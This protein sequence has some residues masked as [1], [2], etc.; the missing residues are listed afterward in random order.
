VSRTISASDTNESPQIACERLASSQHGVLS[1][2]Q[3][4]AVGLSRHAIAYLVS[5]GRWEIVRPAVYGVRGHP[6]TWHQQVMSACLWAGAGAVA[7]HHSA[8]R[9]WGM[10]GLESDHVEISTISNMRWKG[11]GVT[12]H[13]VAGLVPADVGEIAAVPVT[14]APRTLVDIAGQIDETRLEIALDDALRRRLVSVPRMRWTLERLGGKGRAGTAALR[15]L[16]E[17]RR[18]GLPPPESAL[19]T[20]LARLLRSAGLPEPLRQHRIRHGSKVVARV[21]F[22]YPEVRLAI[23]VDGYRYHTGKQDWLRDVR[24]RTEL[25]AL[26]WTVLVFTWDDVER[27]PDW[28]VE[29]VRT[30]LAV[31]L[32][33]PGSGAARAA[34]RPKP[35]RRRRGRGRAPPAPEGRG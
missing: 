7:S 34:S 22:A 2:G 20:R 23:E 32:G 12:V 5:S 25:A 6:P 31:Q 11:G 35:A 18:P 33:G 21:D 30:K 15:K 27:R 17:A 26:G 8:A 3:A 19:E 13:R 28:V 4:V 29:Q 14:A 10:P 1:R 24:R 9:L 16:L